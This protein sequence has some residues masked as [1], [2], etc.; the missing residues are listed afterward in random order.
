M[1]LAWKWYCLLEAAGH[2]ADHRVTARKFHGDFGHF[3]KIGFM[4]YLAIIH[5]L[6]LPGVAFRDHLDCFRTHGEAYSLAERY[7]QAVGD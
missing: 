7:G 6:A 3:A 1:S 4:Q 2:T 5:H